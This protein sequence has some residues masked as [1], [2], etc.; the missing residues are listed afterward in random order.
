MKVL[1]IEENFLAVGEELSSFEHSGVVIQSL[2]YEY[3]SSYHSG[4][5]K[6]PEAILK[7]SHFVELFDEEVD[8]ETIKRTG[9]IATLQALDFG[10]KVDAD[11]VE[12]IRSHTADLL[13]LEKF[14]VSLGAEH[15]VT[16]G[17]IQA[18]KEFF[19]DFCIL[20]IDAH[21][22]L[23]ASYNDN[24]YSH[25]SVMARCL[26]L[27]VP[28]TQ[29][30]IRAQSIEERKVCRT[31]DHVHTFYA[32]EVHENEDWVKDVLRTL[33]KKVYVTLDAD[34]FDPSVIPSVG[35]AEPNGLTWK[36]GTDLLK[37]V[38]KKHEIIGFD[39][40]EVMPR[41]GDTSSEY[42]CAKLIY[43]LLGYIFQNKNH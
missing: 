31:H 20:Q 17:I 30:G 39:L 40:V 25:A 24:I 41:E 11:A 21:S 10:D 18:F 5:A 36:Q 7:A 3:T 43:R 34:G 38:A 37:K 29:V 27:G 15:T 23:R 35:T 1:G 28:I 12:L 13:K 22:D 42:T 33:K 4:S 19:K 6:G 32:H 16:L 9:G 2:P 8:F 26:E 14:V